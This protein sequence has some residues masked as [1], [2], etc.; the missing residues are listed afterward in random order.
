MA[1]TVVAVG[2]N[3]A[4]TG[5]AR[6]YALQAM[7]HYGA[8]SKTSFSKSTKICPQWWLLQQWV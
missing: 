6:R 3:I 4:A 7:R 1:S 8:S 2:L 5:F